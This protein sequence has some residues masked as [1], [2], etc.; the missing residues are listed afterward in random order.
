VE[1]DTEENVHRTATLITMAKQVN[2]A[3]REGR[4]GVAGL[5]GKKK[6]KKNSRDMLVD[7]I[8]VC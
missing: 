8:C 4:S 7:Q 6:K 5:K 2:V 3:T 1:F